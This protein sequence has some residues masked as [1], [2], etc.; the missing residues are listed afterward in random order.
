M[1]HR[2]EDEGKAIMADGEQGTGGKTRWMSQQTLVVCTFS[3]MSMRS[4]R[5]VFRTF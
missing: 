3:Q 2:L 5:N 1:V 4:H